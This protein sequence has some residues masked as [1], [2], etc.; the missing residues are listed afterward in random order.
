[1]YL[2]GGNIMTGKLRQITDTIHQTVYLSELE[3]KMMSTAYFYRLH[4]VYQSSTVYLTFPCNRTKRYE[5]SY[6]TMQLAGDLFFSSITNASS[7]T[8]DLFFEEAENQINIIAQRLLESSSVPTYCELSKK[9]L[10]E[11][12]P[13]V[14][15]DFEEKSREI[16]NIAYRKASLIDDAALNHYIPPFD[17]SFE[18]R[19][20]IYQCILEAVRIVALFHDIGHPPYSHIMEY[21]LKDLYDC[22]VS[23]NGQY[24]HKRASELIK[25]L[26]PF[27]EPTDDITC[28]ISSSGS[29]TALHE[30]VGI[31]MLVGSFEDVLLSILESNSRR[32]SNK[33]K[34][35]IVL[36][37]IVIAEFCFSILRESSNFF[38]SLHRIVDGCIDADR[39]DYIVRD[40][41]NSGIDWGNIPY[42]RIIESSKLFHI[43]ESFFAVAYPK[44]MS[45]HIDDLLL[46]RYKIFSRI[47]YHHRSYKTA[48]ILQRLV[49]CLAEDYLAK[50]KEQLSL[51]PEIS[52]LWNCL[53]QTV[54]SHDL[55]IIQWND[56]TLISH[57]YHTLAEIK[58]RDCND[59][60]I[61]S[62]KYSEINSMLEEFLLNRKHFYSVF[63]RQSDFSPI[64]EDV[65]TR[66]S[67][68]LQ[69]VNEYEQEKLVKSNSQEIIE[70]AEDSIKRLDPS[71]LNGIIQLGD[72]DALE[73]I[74]PS[75]CS[76]KTIIP[77][78]LK[79]YSS[80]GKIGD[81]VFDEN[82]FRTKTGLPDQEDESDAIY[83]YEPDIITP[84]KYNTSTLETQ[85]VAQQ[86]NCLQYIAY[87]ELMTEDESVIEGIR[88]SIKNK[89]FIALDSSMKE[90]FSCLR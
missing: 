14:K 3:S 35:T 47:N 39:M 43:K 12:L 66:L 82:I 64:F 29:K 85:L 1:M 71:R 58:S 90:N 26:K 52:D 73:R 4:D 21:T 68:Q 75:D 78:V 51:C 16:V 27:I 36:Y 15:T 9:Q 34:Y 61:D 13:N 18:K 37:Y 5:H 56:S 19:R 33:D 24:N 30:Q 53:S 7:S 86:Q 88:S 41:R 2:Y 25:N 69:R 46:I 76:L 50:N 48:L 70:D 28:L 40:S 59:Y 10:S 23:D 22:C 74:F 79:E 89:L 54:N 38:K 49:K 80:Q 6:G 44:K 84:T 72:A 32:K 42:K 65:L 20:F 57:L 45:E 62:K 87:V 63:K 67:S 17:Q 31:R 83:L 8:Q 55:F 81:F 77:E 11:C 60:N